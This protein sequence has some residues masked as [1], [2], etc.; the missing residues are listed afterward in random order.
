MRK[1]FDGV[2]MLEGVIGGRPLQLMYLRGERASVLLDTGCA[3]DPAGFIA[4]QI[5]QT[6]GD[7]SALSWIIN[8]HID[9]DHTGGN[10]AMKRIAPRALLACGDADRDAAADPAVQR[11]TR[12]DAYRA[13][14][15]IFYSPETTTW[16]E[17]EGGAY[18]PID[19]T[20]V[21]GERLLLSDDWLVE[22]LSL[23][24][25]AKGH[26]GLL[27][28][29][30]KA[31]YGGD[32][33]H[34]AGCLG[35]DGTMKLCPTYLHVDDTLATIRLIE[36]LP[37]TTY[38]GCHWPVMTGPAIR[39]FCAE[40]RAYIERADALMRAALGRQPHTLRQ[41]CLALGPQLG[42]WDHSTPALDLETVFSLHGHASRL[43]ER[44]IAT[45]SRSS[46]GVLIYGLS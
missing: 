11:R 41:L 31:L 24:G 29:R 43:V 16:L 20:F 34:G 3:G 35:L 1:I 36:H 19:V 30:H 45:A 38:I 8:S 40:S 22:I 39:D 9:L 4:P 32:A 37:I 23:P 2:F 10:H 25:H 21:G 6:G 12:Y 15:A 26:L 18:E 42:E 13:D 46:E 33:I 17:R 44:G 5:V 27:D 7:P 28:H 14:H